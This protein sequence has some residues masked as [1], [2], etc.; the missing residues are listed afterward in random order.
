MVPGEGRGAGL[1]AVRLGQLSAPICQSPMSERPE[2][3][4]TQLSSFFLPLLPASG[5]RDQGV[6][7]SRRT[8]TLRVPERS[9]E[10]SVQVS[11]RE[12]RASARSSV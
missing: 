7:H 9:E 10:V 2:S 11:R 1:G 4:S 5:D 3:D 8:E 12:S 6:F